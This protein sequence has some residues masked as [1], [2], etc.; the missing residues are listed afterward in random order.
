MDILS[1][2]NEN[3]SKMAKDRPS[4]VSTA[5]SGM[6]KQMILNNR[7]LNNVADKLD[8]VA[9]LIH[10]KEQREKG[11]VSQISEIKSSLGLLNQIHYSRITHIH[12]LRPV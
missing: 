5:V 4:L 6:S 8:A 12:I 11:K 1:K 9:D 3:I 7:E 10:E 2:I